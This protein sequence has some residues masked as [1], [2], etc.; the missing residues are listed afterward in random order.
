MRLS[1]PISTTAFICEGFVAFLRQIVTA[2]I[3]RSLRRAGAGSVR[4]F[5]LFLQCEN[6]LG[7]GRA[8]WVML[9]DSI[10]ELLVVFLYMLFVLLLVE[11]VLVFR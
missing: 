8:I 10:L 5:L 9:M 2:Q 11:L 7:R 3:R 6:L 4:F 1:P